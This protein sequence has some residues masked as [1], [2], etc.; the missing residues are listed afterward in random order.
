[1]AGQSISPVRDCEIKRALD[2]AEANPRSSLPGIAFGPTRIMQSSLLSSWHGIVLERHFYLPGERRSGSIDKHVMSM[3]H[4]APARFEYRNLAG[5]FIMA[6]IRPRL[7][8]ITP[9]GSIPDIRLHTS[10]ELTHCGL[11]DGFLRSVANELDSRTTTPIF[12]AGIDD[13]PIQGIFY[14]LTD[15]LEAEH[16]SGRLYVDSLAYALATRYLLL[17]VARPETS[18]PRVTGLVPHLLNR[19]R[20]KIEENLDADLSLESLAKESGYSRAHFLRM[21]RTATGLTPHQYVLELRLRRAQER[22]KQR[23]SSIIDVALSCGFA[24]QSHMTSVF[25]RRLEMTP[26]EFRRNAWS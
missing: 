11:E 13:K 20:S 4:G 18:K 23:S 14:L 26:G 8:M 12:H 10:V 5:D 3:S 22:L 17:D 21:F 24:S 25:R 16:R 1:M 7:I 15:E 19:V 6:L 9:L 2:G